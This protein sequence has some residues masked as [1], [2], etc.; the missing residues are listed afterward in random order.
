MANIKILFSKYFLLSK[1]N[2]TFDKD[3]KR[4]LDSSVLIDW[5]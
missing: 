4:K 3:P 1:R 2:F 5:I